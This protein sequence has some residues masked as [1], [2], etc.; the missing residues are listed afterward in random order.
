MRDL[1]DVWVG[2]VWAERGSASAASARVRPFALCLGDVKRKIA[3][4]PA[5]PL[6]RSRGAVSPC[7]DA[8]ARAKHYDQRHRG[9]SQ[10]IRGPG[11]KRSADREL[12]GLVID[13]D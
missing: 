6:S 10:P 9:T 2:D 13:I 11:L 4:R 5:S 3:T 1:S 7:G 8:G 12:R